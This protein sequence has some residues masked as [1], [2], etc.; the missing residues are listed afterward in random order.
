M[1]DWTTLLKEWREANEAMQKASAS[2][3]EE[4]ARLQREVVEFERPDRERIQQIEAELRPSAL[5]A[6]KTVK[7]EESGVK[8][9]YRKGTTRVT[10]DW[11]AVDSINAVLRDVMPSAASA[12][13]AARKATT[14]DPSVKLSVY[15]EVSGD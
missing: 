15:A 5:A 4:I 3:R 1:V 12:L 6:G 7:H 8:V 9:A 2:T 11:K 14:G 13:T 10:Y